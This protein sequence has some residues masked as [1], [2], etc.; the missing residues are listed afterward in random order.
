MDT[1]H[2]IIINE[3]A[4]RVS[5]NLRGA[6]GS[7][8]TK[9]TQ[10]WADYGYKDSLEF[11]DHYQMYR[12]FGIAKAGI[13]TPVNQCWKT[14]PMI[15]EGRKGEDEN[16]DID[17]SFEVEIAD[18]FE[19]KNIW[20]KLKLA[21]EYQRV[22]HYGAFVVQ[23]RGTQ[24]QADWSKPL[25]R[26]RADQIVKFIPLFEV[27]LEPV[28]WE[29]DPASERYGQPVTYQFQESNLIDD[30]DQD[31]RLRNVTVHWSRV[32]IFA[33]GADSD[34][35]YGVPANEG[36]FNDLVTME[37]II[38]AGGEGFWKNAKMATVYTNTNKDAN[39]PGPDEIDA[40]D[41]AIQDF[42]DGLDQHLMTGSLDPKVLA[43]SLADPKEHF[44][45][46]L[47]SY[48]ASI[49]VASKILVGAQEGRLA[50]DGDAKATS[51][52][53]QSRRED[54]CS[55]M[56]KSV[57]DWLMSVGAV[58]RRK[59]YIDWDDLMAPSDKEKFE[60]GEKLTKVIV[61]LTKIYGESPIDPT[62]V[63]K[64]M[65]YQP[66]DMQTDDMSESDDIES[67]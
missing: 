44:L 46:A 15:L 35:I 11:N 7:R 13:K 3:L 52:G 29:N 17:T 14:S 34:S 27:Q 30:N 61:E 55:D 25:S 5:A 60:L 9:H 20:R 2:Q 50:A 40:M 16:R 39:P 43:S 42:V 48:S 21:D 49:E 22:G 57:I 45:I 66:Q 53:F 26:I 32:I 59:Y 23:I 24:E 47:Q 51:S 10:A 28:S 19:S 36:G 4:G 33:E 41:Q 58:T 56:I 38:G 1:R 64:I 67:E 65:G 6:Y 12:R 18:I 31:Q 62:E 54:W 37:K 63:A 8:D